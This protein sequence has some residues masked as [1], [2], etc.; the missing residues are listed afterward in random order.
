MSAITNTR[1]FRTEKIA[2]Y[3]FI[4]P[5]Y[6]IL[7]LWY[8]CFELLF[9]IIR[10]FNFRSSPIEPDTNH[11]HQLIFFFINK[12]YKFNNLLSNNFSSFIIIIY[13]IIIFYFSSQDINNTQFQ[14]ILI[15]LSI[16]VY[17]FSYIKLLKWKL[18]RKHKY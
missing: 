15:S 4:S 11:L 7:L 12:K 6:I 8:P 3:F 17:S 2:P 10:K 1:R 16:I 5:F 9:S 18:N 14:V 13:N